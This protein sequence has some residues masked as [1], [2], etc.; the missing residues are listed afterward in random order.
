MTAMIENRT[1]TAP[2]VVV[3]NVRATPEGRVLIVRLPFGAL[4]WNRPSAVIVQRDGTVERR[5]IVDVTLI[6]YA[7]LWACALAAL[8]A[9]WWPNRRKEH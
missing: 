4:V 7:T 8:L 2:P 3:G 5:Q 6:A 9:G 1:T